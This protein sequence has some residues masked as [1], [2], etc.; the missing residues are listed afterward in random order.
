MFVG[1]KRIVDKCKRENALRLMFLQQRNVF[2]FN[3]TD[4]R[5]ISQFLNI[6]M[7]FC[8]Q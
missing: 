6:N 4:D 2:V 3:S 1:A 5:I 8:I 7:C